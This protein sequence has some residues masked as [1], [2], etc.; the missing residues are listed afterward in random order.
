MSD[1]E[2]ERL[3]E[4]RG[5]SINTNGHNLE[6][7]PNMLVEDDVYL[8]SQNPLACFD[9]TG[10]FAMGVV[11]ILVGLRETFCCCKSRALGDKL[12]EAGVWS[13]TS[14]SGFLWGLVCGSDAVV[15]CISAALLSNV[16]EALTIAVPGITSLMAFSATTVPMTLHACRNVSDVYSSSFVCHNTTVPDRGTQPLLPVAN[17]DDCQ[18]FETVWLKLSDLAIFTPLLAAPPLLFLAGLTLAPVAYWTSIVVKHGAGRDQ[19]VL[20]RTAWWSFWDIGTVA[21]KITVFVVIVMT[22]IFAAMD[23]SIVGGVAKTWVAGCTGQQASYSLNPLSLLEYPIISAFVVGVGSALWSIKKLFTV[24]SGDQSYRWLQ[25]DDVLSDPDRTKPGA[26]LVD[27]LGRS[28]FQR[29]FAVW[30]VAHRATV[31]FL[32]EAGLPHPLRWH[33]WPLT[34]AG[35]SMCL[36]PLLFI[37]SAGVFVYE[38]MG[39]S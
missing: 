23:Y 6:L 14:I 24:L 35:V 18:Y 11:C 10:P 9:W 26:S 21:P 25:Y 7:P 34:V 33:G 27:P 20:T 22:G 3:D 32:L 39:L 37:L 5:S 16:F 19:L 12:R 8:D 17:A 38:T 31:L 4:H 30:H 13:S 36:L 28:P 2:Y 1:R 29:D 15:D